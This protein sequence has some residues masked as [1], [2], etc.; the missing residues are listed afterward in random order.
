[1]PTRSSQ[2]R[3]HDFATNARRIVVAFDGADE[4]PIPGPRTLG[5][6]WPSSSGHHWSSLPQSKESKSR[7]PGDTQSLGLKARTGPT[8]ARL[9][10]ACPASGGPV[11]PGGRSDGESAE[12][13]TSGAP[14]AAKKMVS[15]RLITKN[16]SRNCPWLELRA[17]GV[18][19]LLTELGG[20][21]SGASPDCSTAQGRRI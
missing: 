18:G 2:P 3:D 13:P 7:R 8:L 11:C 16:C 21:H 9:V 15:R 5:R 14:S 19:P 4:R 17:A 6:R 10:T 12:M 20:R 1:M